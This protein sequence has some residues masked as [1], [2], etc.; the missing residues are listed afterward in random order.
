MN[1]SRPHLDLTQKIELLQTVNLFAGLKEAGYQILAQEFEPVRYSPGEL[2]LEIDQPVTEFLVI[3]SG[4]AG[5][6]VRGEVVAERHKG[7]YLGEMGALLGE[8][9]SATVRAQSE[10]TLLKMPADRFQVLVPKSTLLGLLQSTGERRKS[11]GLRLSEALQHTPQGLFK[12]DSKGRFTLD[13]SGKCLEYFGVK[14]VYDLRFKEFAALMET[15]SPG[16][17]ALWGTYPT[18]FD[19][20]YDSKAVQMLLTLLP[21]EVNLPSPQG[22]PR[23]FA[24]TYYPCL[25]GDKRLSALDVGMVDITSQKDLDALQ[26][27]QRRLLYLYEDPESYYSLMNLVA[28][29]QA[30]LLE[31][32]SNPQLLRDLHTL[33]GVAGLFGFEPIMSLCHELE[34]QIGLAGLEGV[35]KELLAQF[36][37]ESQAP[38]EL[39][40]YVTPELRRRLEGVVLSTNDF[41]KLKAAFLEKA[42]RAGLGI[43]ERAASKRLSVLF[44]Q[45]ESLSIRLA[46]QLGKEVEF[47]ALGGEVLVPPKL[48]EELKVLVHLFRN[49]LDHGIESPEVRRAHQKPEKGL[50]R[51]QAA[52]DNQGLHLEVCDDGQGINREKLLSKAIQKGLV[53][54]DAKPSPQEIDH[55]IFHPGL[56]TQ[57]GVNEISGRGRCNVSL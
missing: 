36:S 5:I 6:L 14:D 31:T 18:L 40:E 10:V 35:E 51:I 22:K 39:L 50:L 3:L 54:L 13:I 48:F 17:T 37:V 32:Q 20:K 26:M 7:D 43:L 55:L 11:L 45:F 34:E 28:Q 56:S 24:L 12:L 52:R 29:V 41:N 4:V 30:G 33:K 25:D 8:L 57:E 42:D 38:V 15:R 16:F 21:G 1:Q 53:P 2:I 44:N 47:E 9:A 27:R 19:P 49:S 46:N 23:T